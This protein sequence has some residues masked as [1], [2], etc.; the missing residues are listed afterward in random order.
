[1]AADERIENETM[2]IR[3]KLSELAARLVPQTILTRIVGKQQPQA[4]AHMMDVDRLHGMLRKAEQGDTEELF[5]L[6]RDIVAGHAHTQGEFSKRKL[7]VLGE[8][9]TLTPANPK[10]A[11]EAAFIAD[12]QTHLID[13]PQWSDFLSHS[14][15]SSLYPV[16]VSE[17]IYRPSPRPGWRYEVAEI[18]KVPHVNLMWPEGVVSIRDT[19]ADGNFTG[20][21]TP[22]DGTRYLVHRGNLLSSVPDW[23]G[24]PMRSILFW[25][26]FATMGRDWWARFL[27]RFGSPFLV[28][29]Y[30]QTD[31]RGRYELQHA[32]SEATRIFGLAISKETDVAIHQANATGGG[33]AFEKFQT[34]ANNEISKAIIGQPGSAASSGPKI[35][36]DGQATA[37]SEVRED[38]RKYDARMLGVLIRSKILIPLWR[39]NGWTVPLP[40][41]NFGA[42][43][44]EEADLTGDLLSSLY[45]AGLE[46]TDEGLEILSAKL[47]LP[48]R[49]LPALPSPGR[50]LSAAGSPLLPAV[51]RRAA[52]ARQARG[53]VDAL[54]A[55]ASPK[56][57]R[58]MRSRSLELAAAVEAADSPEAAA[59]A[60]AALAAD[61]DPA[62]AAEL[63]AAVLSSA[64]VNAVI[65]LD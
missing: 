7:A 13:L 61:Y 59:A 6:Y 51:A 21:H 48:L 31:D 36:G 49:R 53:A 43:T 22:L 35:G 38:I 9:M 25:W 3:A 58:L 27:D 30:E 11:T 42:V 4:V 19:D 26:L 5:A 65:Q 63:V 44:E 29:K 16:A 57:A 64:A 62:G 47:G 8:P 39:L 34:F 52:R 23:W 33:D 18:T 46:P 10:I 50:A 54:A 40:T 14:L 37:Q 56:L 55:A 17:R 41:V 45:T 24:G 60:V 1:M 20:A 28:G 2:N 12:V 32:F 15:D